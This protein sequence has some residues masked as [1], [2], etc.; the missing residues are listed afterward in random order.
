VGLV[1]GKA[2]NGERQAEALI[3]DRFIHISCR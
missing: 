2:R 1:H 3:S